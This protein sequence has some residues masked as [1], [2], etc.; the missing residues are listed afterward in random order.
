MGRPPLPVGTHGEIRCYPTGKGRFRA[1]ANF[2]DHDG[3]TRPVERAGRSKADA[4]RRL[5]EAL[6]DR[7]RRTTGDEMTDRTKVAVVAERWLRE[8]D[9]SGKAARTKTTYRESWQRDL[10]KAVG[11]L[12]LHEMTVPMVDRVL[13]AIRDNTGHGSAIHA[14]VVLSGLLRMAVTHGALSVNPVREVTLGARKVSEDDPDPFTLS[15]EDLTELREIV[16]A[17]KKAVRADLIDLVDMLSVLGCR[18]GELL[19]LDWS[20]VDFTAGT[21]KIEGTVIRQPKVGLF[22]QRHTKS[23]AGM[24]TLCL[25]EWAMAL[26]RR[27]ADGDVT[28]WVFPSAA[29]TLR[30]PE[31]T[32]TQLR[33][34]V[35]GTRFEGLHPHAFRHL[36]A[37]MLDEAGL[38]AREIADYLGHEKIS[39]TQDVYMARR[40]TGG[41]AAR[42]LS[43]LHRPS[44]EKRG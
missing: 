12:Q 28:G 42:A 35:A 5:K 39:M 17:S 20:R 19:A 6:R 25:P 9:E 30:D 36:V 38:S 21:V 18:I 13:R 31:N 44:R 37:L 22:V 2:R 27:R 14:K 41:S 26:L 43:D 1:V 33:K 24:R 4:Q 10:S 40:A 3:V 29:G 23:R 16:S 7:A 32:R 11:A 34:A 15:R 8:I